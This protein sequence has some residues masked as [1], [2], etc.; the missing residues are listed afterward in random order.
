MEI[1]RAQGSFMFELRAANDLAR[2]LADERRADEASRL[3]E[4][5][6]QRARALAVDEAVQA[7]VNA[8]LQ[9]LRGSCAAA[10]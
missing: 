10:G 6:A 3:L 8:G 2:L 4:D 9:S 5:L 7:E 1:A